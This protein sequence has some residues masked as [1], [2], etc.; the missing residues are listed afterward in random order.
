MR[1]KAKPGVFPDPN[2]NSARVIWCLRRRSSD[3]RC[4]LY[5][6]TLPIE[7]RILQ[8][9]DVVL[10]EI[11]PAEELALKWARLYGERLKRQGWVEPPTWTNPLR[12]NH[13]RSAPEGDGHDRGEG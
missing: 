11:F 6:S 7:V 3:V 8:D 5:A 12:E 9:R 10:T 2:G 4:V 1:G 13:R